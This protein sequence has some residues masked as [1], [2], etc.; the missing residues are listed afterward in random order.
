MIY[1]AAFYFAT[2]FTSFMICI[3]IAL[4][5]FSFLKSNNKLAQ[6][7][8]LETSYGE[9][10]EIKLNFTFA[11]FIDTTVTILFMSIFLGWKIVYRALFND[12]FITKSAF[13]IYIEILLEVKN[14]A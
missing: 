4:K 10:P 8:L 13:K 12:N 3:C 5:V 6:Q 14:D 2:V 7:D 11:F 1:L 9:L